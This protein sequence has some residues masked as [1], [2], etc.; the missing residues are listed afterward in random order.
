MAQNHLI[1]GV[2]AANLLKVGVFLGESISS[3]F[4]KGAVHDDGP[5]GVIDFQ[6]ILHADVPLSI[7][8]IV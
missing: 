1:S 5:V 7:V 6:R 2:I 4:G 3:V 8:A